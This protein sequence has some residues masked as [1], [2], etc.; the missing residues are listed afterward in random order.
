M[1]KYTK[2]MIYFEEF[3]LSQNIAACGW[4]MLQAD[5]DSCA[6]Q[7]DEALGNPGI[8]IFTVAVET[9]EVKDY[10]QYCYETGLN[11]NESWRVFNS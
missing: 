6:A 11:S 9:C 1:K 8:T 10:E 2:P 5:K 7:G 3:E 4:D